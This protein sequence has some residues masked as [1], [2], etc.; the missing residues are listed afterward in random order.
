MNAIDLIVQDHR[1]VEELFAELEEGDGD[2]TAL[3]QDVIR[4]LSIHA[5]I[6]EQFLYP[7]MRRSLPDGD[8]LVEEAL[9]EHQEAKEV[10][11]ELDGM[12]EEDPDFDARVR[13][14]IQDVRHHVEEEEGELLPKIRTALSDSEL[15]EMG[16]RM[17][18]AKAVAPTRPHPRAPSTPPGV[19]VA[20]AV[21]GV[22]DRARDAVSGRGA[23][24]RKEPAAKKSQAKKSQ[25][26]K[27]QATRPSR[28]AAAT[29]PAGRRKTAAKSGGGKRAPARKPQ[30]RARGAKGPVYHVTPEGGG[31]W[32]AAKA[33][34]SRA[35][36]RGDSKSEVVRRAREAAKSQSG[37]LVIH[38][39]DGKI[40][41]ERTYGAD[42]RR[43]RG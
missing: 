14:L 31:G 22:V 19:M 7:A 13:T 20:G 38:K 35:L 6:E 15:E 43:S 36:A 16:E 33:G 23:R 2:R 11:A 5:A 10:L 37:R 28:K 9:D 27:T 30:G 29:R 34:S 17:E 32:R 4:E 39:A 3:V 12:E 25:A 8:Q 24:A 41:E 40:Q 42:P 21:A 26:K 1:E 18:R